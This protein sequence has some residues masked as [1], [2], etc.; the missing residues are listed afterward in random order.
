MRAYVTAVQPPAGPVFL[1]LPNDDGEKPALG[2][3]EDRTVATRV[4]PDPARG[5]PSS[6]M[7]PTTPIT[8]GDE[9]CTR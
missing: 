4:A 9:V 5:P 8:P 6:P 3:A 2:P 1:S 7:W